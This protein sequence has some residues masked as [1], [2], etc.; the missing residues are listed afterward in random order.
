MKT[1]SEYILDI[2]GTSFIWI[3][4]SDVVLEPYFQLGQL[5]IP[6]LEDSEKLETGCEKVDFILM[7]PLYKKVDFVYTGYLG[8][9]RAGSSS[10]HI[11]YHN[12][13]EIQEVAP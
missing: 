3:S 13:G 4:P 6:V 8:S 11:F 2:V 9:I 12:T 7:S 5:I 1:V 10:H